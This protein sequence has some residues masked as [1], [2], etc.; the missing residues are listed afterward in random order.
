M[1]FILKNSIFFFV[2]LF[3]LNRLAG[4]S[5]TKINGYVAFLGNSTVLQGFI[6]FMLTERK[7]LT[8]FLYSDF[9]IFLSLKSLPYSEG[10]S[11]S[12]GDRGRTQTASQLL[13]AVFD[14]RKILKGVSY[15]KGACMILSDSGPHVFFIF[16]RV[17]DNKDSLKYVA[18]LAF[19]PGS[20]SD[21]LC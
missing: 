19:L 2:S 20:E 3:V 18:L 8:S 6:E 15:K 17:C 16:M 7:D 21:T 11:V 12:D 5:L 10:V 9:S 14:D 13:D 4:L 1:S